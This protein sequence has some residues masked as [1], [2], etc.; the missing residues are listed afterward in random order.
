MCSS[1][2][3]GHILVRVSVLVKEGVP[4]ETLDKAMKNIGMPV[5]PLTLI[6]KVGVDVASKVAT[7]LAGADLGGRMGGG[8]L[9]LMTNMVEKGWTG[10]KSKQA[11]FTYSG[12]K[13]KRLDKR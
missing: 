2:C 12:K 10:C 8:D 4:I 5:G 9:L 7:S 11:F 3:L 1:H 13:I 6:D